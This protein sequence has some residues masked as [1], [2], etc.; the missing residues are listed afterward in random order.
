MA[1]DFN[2]RLVKPQ[3][4]DEKR[5]IGTFGL[6]RDIKN[7]DNFSDKVRD[8]RDKLLEFCRVRDMRAMNTYF[9]QEDSKLATYR[10]LTTSPEVA[11]SAKTH[12]QIDYVLI[13]ANE[14]RTVRN[15]IT[16]TNA[17]LMTDHY[18]LIA[19][20]R[21]L[22]TFKKQAALNKCKRYCAKEMKMNPEEMN[23][24]L[25]E[26]WKN[27]SANTYQKWVGLYTE[28]VEKE[29]KQPPK[30]WRDYITAET[31]QL[32]QERNRFKSNGSGEDA[33]RLKKVIKTHLKR[34]RRIW[35]DKLV[36]SDLTCKEQWAGI[37]ILREGYK[38]RRYARNDRHGKPVP[39]AGRADAAAEYLEKEQWAPKGDVTWQE[40]T[41]MVKNELTRRRE[42]NNDL[43]YNTG[44]VS[45][46][47]MKE[48]Q[49][50]LKRNKA[51][52]PDDITTDFIKDLEEDNLE[53]LR[54]LVNEWWSKGEVPHE[55][56]RARV[57]SLYK[58]GDPNKQENYRPI[59][60]LNSFYKVIASVIKKRL[61]EVVDER[62]MSTQY[63]FRKKKS[64]KHA[65][66]IARRIQ[67]FAERAGLPGTLVLLDW[68]KAFDKV[69]HRMLLDAIK[70]YN[71]PDELMRLLE[72][73]YAA[74]EFFVEVEGV[75]SGTRV[76]STGIRQGCPLSP[77]LFVMVM[78]CVFDI[79]EPVAKIFCRKFFQGSKDEQVQFQHV[80]GLGIHFSELLFADDTLLFAEDGHSLDTLLWAVECVSGAY[81]LK[82]N[83]GKCQQIS[84]NK[85]QQVYFW[86]GTAVPVASKAEYLGGVLNTKTDP[87]MEVNRRIG[88]AGAIWRKLQEFWRKGAPSRRKRILYYDALI[89]SKLLYGLE[90]L[91]LSDEHLNKLNAF[92][93]KGLRQIMEFKTT[94]VDR[95]NT[96]AKLMILVNK[97]LKRAE[98]DNKR[99]ITV[100]E[101]IKNESSKLLGDIIR[102]AA[103]DPIRQVTLTGDELNLPQSNRIGRPRVNWSI[104]NVTRVWDLEDV[105]KRDTFGE[106]AFD[107]KKK[108]HVEF[109]IDAAY[110]KL[111]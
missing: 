97:E 83:R 65:I 35:M 26:G 101:R 6:G 40:A 85:A 102:R 86:D 49:K 52:G 10:P 98:G 19:E 33:I 50:Q 90:T 21:I 28:F 2:A 64:T 25:R 1:G 100:G 15:V 91:P 104:L 43:R 106:A 62:L 38:P 80:E 30:P 75:K 93:Y 61:E 39:L 95:E 51:P 45:L 77:Y 73:L 41:N 110:A 27:D 69:D 12:E 60:L 29:N 54:I 44:E 24:F 92:F 48:F 76:Q 22:F 32:I 87:C 81:G 89:A 46:E 96:N 72:S 105:G 58:K 59:S 66:F 7:V 17:L 94:Y 23:A 18:P 107:H 109:I 42:R 82:L 70:S 57:A 74:P 36:A 37:K 34:D 108:D 78:N 103:N 9:K 31:K 13:N 111:F 63:G 79:V 16:D 67:E 55:I 3:T 53:K 5:Y 56:L 99:F 4:E 88:V 71:V 14:A 20:L 8:N 11:I 68:E 47:E 84:I